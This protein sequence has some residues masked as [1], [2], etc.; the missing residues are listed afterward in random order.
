[1]YITNV[2]DSMEYLQHD[3]MLTWTAFEPFNLC[4][5]CNKWSCTYQNCWNEW[6]ALIRQRCYREST[7]SQSTYTDS[8]WDSINSLF[9]TFA[10]L[11]VRKRATFADL[12]SYTHA[13]CSFVLLNEAITIVFGSHCLHA[14]LI[15]LFGILHTI[16]R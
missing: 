9:A 14:L 2:K 6:N 8:M 5:S 16:Y 13:Y 12:H 15:W 7:Y 11:H 1:M 4:L 3:Y 10:D